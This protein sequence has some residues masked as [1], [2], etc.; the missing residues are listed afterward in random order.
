MTAAAERDL[1]RA[2]DHIEFVLKNPKATDG[3]LDE[4]EAQI[5]C[6]AEF[7]EKFKLAN[8][9][10]LASWGIRFVI[11]NGYLAFYVISEEIK[12]VI[13]VRFLFQKS[14]WNAILRQGFSLL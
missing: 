11:V 2:S 14:N 9:P 3:L 7:L 8:G 4:A 12:H 5:N 13:V 1:L 10:V 6:L